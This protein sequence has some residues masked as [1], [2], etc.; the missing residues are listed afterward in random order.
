MV[1]MAGREFSSNSY[2]MWSEDIS[3]PWSEPIY[4]TSIGFDPSLFHDEDGKHYAAI[5]EWESRE[6]YQAPG[7][8]VIAEISLENGEV[9]GQWKRVTQGFTTRGVPKHHKFINMRATIIYYWPQVG[10]VMRMES[11]SVVQKV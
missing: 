4:L 9:L 10:Q 8:I 7:H 2:M 11:K 1:N 5:L 3:G 6:G